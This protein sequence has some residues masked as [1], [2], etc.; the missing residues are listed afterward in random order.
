ML[1]KSIRLELGQTDSF[2]EGSASRAY[3]LRLPL[4]EQGRIDEGA[5]LSHPEQ[6]TIRRMWPSQAETS[7]RL[8]HKNG[9][10]FF[11]EHGTDGPEEAWTCITSA[12]FSDGAVVNLSEKGEALPFRVAKV[13][14]AF[15]G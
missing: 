7:G 15:S 14:P 1:W 11:V 8:A 5:L 10:W 6:A 4:N 9:H 12:T 2:P 3:V 13:T